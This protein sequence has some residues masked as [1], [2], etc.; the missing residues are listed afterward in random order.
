[1]VIGCL[2]LK[3]IGTPVPEEL[4]VDPVFDGCP[5]PANGP[6]GNCDG[7][8][9]ARVPGRVK[10]VEG[11]MTLCTGVKVAD[12][13]SPALT[14]TGQKLISVVVSLGILKVVVVVYMPP[15]FDEDKTVVVSVGQVIVVVKVRVY[16]GRIRVQGGSH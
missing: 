8:T 2:V 14:V 12:G 9:R 3:K 1:M 5:P 16:G 15:P 11:G 10:M 4:E 6:V 13:G 7:G